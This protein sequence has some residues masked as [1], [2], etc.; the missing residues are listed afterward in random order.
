MR[1]NQC[2]GLGLLFLKQAAVRHVANHRQ[3]RT[4]LDRMRVPLR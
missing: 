1:T 2:G 4:R 3:T